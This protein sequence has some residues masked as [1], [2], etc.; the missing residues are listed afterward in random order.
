MN[1]WCWSADIR[2]LLVWYCELRGF[3]SNGQALVHETRYPESAHIER[4]QISSVAVANFS[5]CTSERGQMIIRPNVSVSWQDGLIAR[6]TVISLGAL[7]CTRRF[8]SVQ[9]RLGTSTKVVRLNMN[10]VCDLYGGSVI[11]SR[12]GVFGDRERHSGSI[13]AVV[14][15]Q[16]ACPSIRPSIGGYRQRTDNF[17]NCGH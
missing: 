14:Q 17:N 13:R 8:P 1:N 5:R 7:P 16:Q 6:V 3:C 10:V 9:L 4:T 12:K 11:V 15:Y 2:L